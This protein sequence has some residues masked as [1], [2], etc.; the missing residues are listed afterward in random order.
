MA[1]LRAH[2][3]ED[4]GMGCDCR[5]RSSLAPAERRNSTV[6]S[7][8][9]EHPSPNSHTHERLSARCRPRVPCKKDPDYIKIGLRVVFNNA[10][11]SISSRHS[12]TRVLCREYVPRS[13]QATLSRT[14]S[15][16]SSSGTSSISTALSS[17]SNILASLSMS[18]SPPCSATAFIIMYVASLV[19]SSATCAAS[20]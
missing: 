11:D 20:P 18:K 1:R 13:E 5:T 8:R 19:A 17:R 16:R 3:G 4:V 14:T 10:R 12:Q 6:P 7:I 15:H 2:G 9:A